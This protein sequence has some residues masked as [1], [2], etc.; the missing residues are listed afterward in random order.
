MKPQVHHTPKK[1]QGPEP[2][3]HPFPKK[4]KRVK[5]VSKRERNIQS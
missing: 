3:K 4:K 5:P 1:V 2:K